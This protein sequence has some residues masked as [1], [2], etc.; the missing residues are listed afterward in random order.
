MMSIE[1]HPCSICRA[2]VS[3]PHACSPLALGRVKFM[4][5]TK[6]PLLTQ[7]TEEDVRR[8]VREEIIRAGLAAVS[9]R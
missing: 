8:I 6:G 1:F 2:M 7:L 9:E 3:G 5:N 4:E